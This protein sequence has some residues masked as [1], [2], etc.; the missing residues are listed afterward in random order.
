MNMKTALISLVAMAGGWA[1][2]HWG[3]GSASGGAP[4][5]ASPEKA[6]TVRSAEEFRPW[7][8]SKLS[9]ELRMQGIAD[10]AASLSAAEWPAFFRSQWDS[11]E[12][13]RIAARL[14]ADNDP[15]GFWTWLKQNKDP[16]HISRFAKDLLECW[17]VADPDAAM[18]AAMQISDKALGDRLRVVPVEAALETDLAKGL[19]LAKR[20]GDFNSFGKW[21]NREWLKKDP[22]LTVTTL[23]GFDGANDYRGYLTYALPF[24][25]EKDSQAAL[26]WMKGAQPL[27]WDDWMPNAFKSVAK[28]DPQAALEAARGIKDSRYRDVALGGVLASGKLDDEQFVEVLDEITLREEGLLGTRISR[29]GDSNADCAAYAKRLGMLPAS[30]NNLMQL[31]S[32]AD[33]WKFL[34]GPGPVTEWANS[35]PDPALRRRVMAAIK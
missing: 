11:P 1:L 17:A 9:P 19:A 5:A 7:S 35:L 15:Q 25:I 20:A 34:H 27:K 26:E 23:A 3:L 18:D 22:A 30:A 12:A 2:G 28:A 8:A 31:E 16:V 21:D 13:T 4:E 33:T 32:F 24:W 29:T 6:S 14:W 10:K